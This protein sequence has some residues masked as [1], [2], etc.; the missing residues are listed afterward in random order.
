M[1]AVDNIKDALVGRFFQWKQENLP[2]LFQ[3]LHRAGGDNGDPQTGDDGFL[4]GLQVVHV[5]HHIQVRHACAVLLQ[6]QVHFLFGA[7]TALAH[8]KGFPP[9][10]LKGGGPV[11]QVQVNQPSFVLLTYLN[12]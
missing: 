8:D 11:L 4:D 12:Q 2:C 10:I 5:R 6:K 7:G 3:V 1:L 9:E